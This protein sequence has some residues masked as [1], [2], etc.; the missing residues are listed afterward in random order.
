MEL[1]AKNFNLANQNN[2][3]R[4]LTDYQ[5]QWL[6]LWFYPK[7]NTPGC[8]L[9]GI[10][11]RD[12]YAEFQK[13]NIAV[14]GISKD[15]VNKHQK[16]CSKYDFPF[17]LLADTETKTCQD[18]GVWVEKSFMGKKYQ[19]I[20]RT[21]FLINPDGEI[22]HFWKKVKVANHVREV[23]AKITELNI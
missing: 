5:G 2:T 15:D 9:E 13:R 6:V 3:F 20:E 21:T 4:Q 12:H 18:Y 16:F 22:I 23:L 19:G 14:V 7:D 1:I 11:F 17:D 8:T 10:A